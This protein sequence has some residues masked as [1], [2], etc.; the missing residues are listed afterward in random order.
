LVQ[1]KQAAAFSRRHISLLSG[2][3]AISV[4]GSLAERE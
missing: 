2:C 4:R 3:P 1:G